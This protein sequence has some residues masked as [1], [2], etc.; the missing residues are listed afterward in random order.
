MTL[1]PPDV[2]AETKP[3]LL[4]AVSDSEPLLAERILDAGS[5]L[6]L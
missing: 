6:Y 3:T 2:F 5:G 1:V 4:G